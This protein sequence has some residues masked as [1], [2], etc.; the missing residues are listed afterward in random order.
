MAIILKKVQKGQVGEICKKLCSLILDGNDALRDI[1]SIGLKTL[2]ADVPDSMGT[3]IVEK[4][5]SNL[6]TG[7][8][9]A[10]GEDVK[11]ECLDIMSELLKRFGGLNEKDHIEIMTVVV[12]QLDHDRPVI[13][14]RATNCLGSLAVVST[15]A[16]L[17]RLVQTLLERIEQA[18]KKTSSSHA[19][20][21]LIQTIGT[22][23]RTVG[24]RLGRHLDRIV[25][26]F[27][28]FC[29]NPDDESHHNDAAN[30]LRENCFPGLESFVLR[31]PREVAPFLASILQVSVAFM[32]YDPNYAYDDDE[33]LDGGD[34]D[35]MDEGDEG[36]EED[37][38]QD[39]DEEYGG[40]GNGSD[41]DDTSWKVRKAAVKV[42]DAVVSSR[43]EG[44]PES[45]GGLYEA[46]GD[47]LI[48]RFKER[49]E[50]VRLDIVACFTHLV[51]VT[52]CLSSTSTAAAAVAQSG[53]MPAAPL[54]KRQR[55]TV[56]QLESRLQRIVSASLVQLSGHSLKTKSSVFGLLRIVVIALDVRYFCIRPVLNLFLCCLCREGWTNLCPSCCRP[57]TGAFSRRTRYGY[58]HSFG[59]DPP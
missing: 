14:K 15:D 34:S 23:S 10:G 57:H 41:D 17:N 8:G 20:R 16:L 58:L 28:R 6:L 36:G 18:E 37:Y 3:L 33:D 39:E 12:G 54:L 48:A 32:K 19:T 13:R 31:C 38:G 26:L 35:R 27:L 45:G 40:G 4:L 2:I 53:A 22:V 21:T 47:S 50:N 1:Y 25:P 51:Q 30:E 49:E 11:R 5:T 29:G 42:I 55:S 43:P 9:R 24:H 52:C 59:V 44:L 46:V 7:I 56:G